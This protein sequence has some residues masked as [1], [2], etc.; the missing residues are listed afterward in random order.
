MGKNCLSFNISYRFGG[1]RALMNMKRSTPLMMMN[2][3]IKL[4]CNL[5]GRYY[6]H[7]PHI[8]GTRVNRSMVD[9][10]IIQSW[11]PVYGFM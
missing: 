6:T 8:N 1:A 2:L 4:P 7:S 9:V 11:L 5:C 10:R 3:Q